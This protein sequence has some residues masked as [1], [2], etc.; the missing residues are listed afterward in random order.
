MKSMPEEI[1]QKLRRISKLNK[2]VSDLSSEVYDILEG[3]GMNMD[4]FD[5]YTENDNFVAVINGGEN[6]IEDDIK[7]I[8]K[9]F[10]KILNKNNI[11]K[12]KGK[13]IPCCYKCK[14]NDFPNSF[15]RKDYHCDGHKFICKNCGEVLWMTNEEYD[16]LDVKVR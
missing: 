1:K 16:K 4:I 9:A 12:Q 14:N 6:N 2:E 7:E 15:N 10:L 8:E 5:E 13:Y 3:Y 11:I